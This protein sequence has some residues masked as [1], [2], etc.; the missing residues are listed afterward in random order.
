MISDSSA[1]FTPLS[2]ARAKWNGISMVWIRA[3][4]AA[5][6]TML[7]SR[8][9]KIGPLPQTIE[10]WP[11]RVVLY[12]GETALTSSYVNTE[13]SVVGFFVSAIFSS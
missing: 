13:G 3:I 7:R 8:G 9:E 5:T 10:E 1:G 4:S 11:F 2:S 6:V 12:A